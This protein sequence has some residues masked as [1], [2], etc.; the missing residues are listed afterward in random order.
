MS[1]ILCRYQQTEVWIEDKE[2]LKP[3]SIFPIP[4]VKEGEGP[5]VKAI[6]GYSFPTVK[7]EAAYVDY[8][9]IGAGTVQQPIGSRGDW[10]F[11]PCL[12]RREKAHLP[13]N[14]GNW[15]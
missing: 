5:C 3:P 14:A 15:E 1:G 9:E 10:D 6:S 4:S 13:L 7:Q 2:A 11:H 8:E 12:A